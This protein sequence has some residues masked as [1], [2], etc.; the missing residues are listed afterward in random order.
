MSNER[1]TQNKTHSEEVNT[2]H[3]TNKDMENHFERY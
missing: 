2:K 1:V 3:T